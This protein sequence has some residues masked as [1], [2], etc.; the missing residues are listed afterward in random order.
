MSRLCSGFER[1]YIIIWR[2]GASSAIESEGIWD[3]KFSRYVVN[4]W[5]IKLLCILQSLLLMIDMIYLPFTLLLIVIEADCKCC[6]TTTLRRLG[7][8][9][10]SP[11]T[12]ALHEAIQYLL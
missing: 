12:V 5:F 10:W 4:I 8:K 9:M 7:G 6:C 11:P 3:V 2:V 1:C